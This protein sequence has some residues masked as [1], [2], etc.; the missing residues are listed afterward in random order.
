MSTPL[1]P[2]VR[3]ITL[4]AISL[5]ACAP[6]H[7]ADLRALGAAEARVSPPGDEPAPTLDGSLERYTDFALREAPSLRA[8]AASWRAAAHRARASAPLPEP[9]LSYGY[10]IRSVETRVGPQRH[11]LSVRQR[12]PWPGELSARETAANYQT[13]AAGKQYDA[14]MLEARL[15]VALAYWTVWEVRAA[16][17]VVVQQRDLLAGLSAAVKTRIEIG[18]A[19]LADAGQVDLDLSRIDDRLHALDARERSAVARLRAAIGAAPATE[20]PAPTDQPVRALPAPADDQLL[21]DAERAPAIERLELEARAADSEADAAARRGY[22]DL[23]LGVDYIET[24]SAATAGVPDSG[25]DPIVAMVGISLPIWR[26]QLRGAEDAARST[27]AARRAHSEALRQSARGRLAEA[28]TEL[29]DSARR[30]DLHDTTLIPQA[31]GVYEAVVGAYQTGDAGLANLL[32][33]QRAILELELELV[34]ARATHARS[35]AMVD[36]LVGRPVER[37]NDLG[38]A[39]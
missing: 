33:A 23:T 31:T 4:F 6:A 14:T 9:N 24:G 39:P 13:D 7:R 19:S 25:K 37:T 8:S 16:R 20:L 21:A 36:A 26:D 35:W 15:R 12:L 27:A 22:P 28:L 38:G 3:S 32:I 11:R 29:R 34:A 2:A 1:R 10:F 5:S 18:K 30:I 17:E